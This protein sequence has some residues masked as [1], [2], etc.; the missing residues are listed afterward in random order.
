MGEWKSWRLILT[1]SIRKREAM[2]HLGFIEMMGNGLCKSS[3]VEK[4]PLLLGRAWGAL[5]GL[6]YGA[7]GQGRKR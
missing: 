6:G 1:A 2:F 5:G 3:R 7:S 4:H